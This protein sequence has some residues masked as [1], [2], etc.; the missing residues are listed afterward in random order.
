MQISECTLI[1]KKKKSMN[2]TDRSFTF[3]PAS[4]KEVLQHLLGILEDFHLQ[5]QLLHGERKY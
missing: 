2:S 1:L 4:L 3:V 5:S